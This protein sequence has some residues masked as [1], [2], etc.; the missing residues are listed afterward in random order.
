LS[1]RQDA[2]E[3]SSSRKENQDPQKAKQLQERKKREYK[4]K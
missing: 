1:K 4:K 3:K 2:V